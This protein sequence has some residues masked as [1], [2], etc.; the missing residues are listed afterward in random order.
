MNNNLNSVVIEGNLT[1]EA[2]FELTSKGTNFCTFSIASNRYYKQGEE[3]QHEVSFFDIEAWGKLCENCRN[4]LNKGAG[5]RIVG[6]LKQDRWSSE[7]G[8]IRSRIKIIA[9]HIEIKSYKLN[10]YAVE[11][12]GEEKAKIKEETAVK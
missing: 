10:E 1:K 3:I 11:A 12:G 7:E 2:F 4:I 9:E 8:K 6:R 5:V